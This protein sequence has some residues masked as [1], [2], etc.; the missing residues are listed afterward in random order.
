MSVG[1]S[2]Y[3]RNEDLTRC[4]E[5]LAKQTYPDFDIIIANGGDYDGVKRVTDNFK[6]LRI[7]IFTQE[8]KG[9]VEARNMCW[10]ESDADIACL[11]DDDLVVSPGWIEAIRETFLSDEKI[12]GVS[13]P[14]II[15]EERM[16]N[17]DLSLFLGQ[18]RSSRNIFLKIAGKMYL[19]IILENKVNEV[20]KILDSGTFTPGSNFP[21]CLKLPAPVEVDY[22]EACHMC[23]RRLLFEKINGFD[24]SYTGTGEWNEPDFAFKV[25]GL[26]YKLIF[27][28]K[29]VT[30]HYISQGGVFK[31]RTYAYER[32]RNF[33]YFYLKNVKV[34]SLN[35]FFRFGT[36]LLFIN[37]YW[38]Y[39]FLQSK[40]TD[41]LCGI[42]GTVKGLLSG[43]KI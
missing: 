16:K 31:A 42:W 5:S 24:Y 3:N 15:P 2:T 20:G 36:N 7:K 11:I 32:S 22:L 35:K 30:R 4:L 23:F 18:F 26:G 10:R 17:R 1:I 39:K 13:G 40:N 33:I 38:L 9:I 43:T 6:N 41:W 19:N 8:R 12:G 27:N 14:T 28:P 34:N 29:A 21:D 37:L 25:R